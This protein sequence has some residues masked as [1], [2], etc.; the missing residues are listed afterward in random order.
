[1]AQCTLRTGPAKANGPESEHL[2]IILYIEHCTLHITCL[3][4]ILQRYH[5][6]LQTSKICLSWSQDFHGEMYLDA[7]ILTKK[8]QSYFWSDCREIILLLL[9]TTLKWISQGGGGQTRLIVF[10][11]FLYLCTF[12]VCFALLNTY[13]VVFSIYIAI[14]LGDKDISFV[15]TIQTHV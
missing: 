14:Q 7:Y 13:L 4:C 6:K 2:N 12:Y 9:L 8:I 11:L 1:M 5:L 10:L 3:Y 15:G